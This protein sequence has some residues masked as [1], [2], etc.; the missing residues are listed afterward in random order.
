MYTVSRQIASK[1]A[2]KASGAGFQVVT[3][4][5]L[6]SMAATPCRDLALSASKSPLMKNRP[7]LGSSRPM[8]GSF[9]L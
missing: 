7:A 6:E 5:V 2:P 8:L 9:R 1:S 3:R 4:P